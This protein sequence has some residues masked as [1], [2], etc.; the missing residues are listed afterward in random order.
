MRC[1]LFLFTGLAAGCRRQQ[2]N[3]LSWTVEAVETRFAGNTAP[4]LLPV[5]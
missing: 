5:A 2:W 3:V 4:S 1:T